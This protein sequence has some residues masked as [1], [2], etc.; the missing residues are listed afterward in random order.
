M[1][2]KLFLLVAIGTIMIS[3]GKHGGVGSVKKADGGI[4]HIVNPAEIRSNGMTN[5]E[6]A[7]GKAFCDNLQYRNT[8]FFTL[9]GPIKK[10]KYNVNLKDCSRAESAGRSTYQYKLT[11]GFLTF[12]QLLD[13]GPV[14]TPIVEIDNNGTYKEFCD[15]R[16]S[17]TRMFGNDQDF[18]YYIFYEGGDCPRDAI[19]GDVRFV[20]SNVVILAKKVMVMNSSAATNQFGLSIRGQDLKTEIYQK[21]GDGEPATQFFT[22][23]SILNI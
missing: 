10:F 5:T 23:D 20:Q 19:C 7:L 8:N 6:K 9:Y 14:I 21:C 11:N 18:K 12:H 22:L 15:V 13:D 1:M 2:K 3:C 17:P 16:N 4:G